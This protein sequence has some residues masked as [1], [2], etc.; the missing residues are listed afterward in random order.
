MVTPEG[1][2]RESRVD[3][4]D[5]TAFF[6]VDLTARSSTRTALRMSQ[7]NRFAPGAGTDLC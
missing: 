7:P 6:L 5:C 1:F 4:T 3:P 2:P